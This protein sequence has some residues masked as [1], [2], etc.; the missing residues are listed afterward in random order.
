MNFPDQ[1]VLMSLQTQDS[2]VS[3]IIFLFT[4]LHRGLNSIKFCH[5]T[6]SLS[7][8][9]PNTWCLTNLSAEFIT[10]V[11]G[12]RGKV[13]RFPPSFRTHGRVGTLHRSGSAILLDGRVFMS[14]WIWQRVICKRRWDFTRLLMPKTFLRVVKL[15]MEKCHEA[16]LLK[17]MVPHLISF[18]QLPFH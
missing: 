1:Q 15:A 7:S 2:F 18:G 17:K 6:P 4:V 11:R 10:T 14:I 8:H 9:H 12:H 13:Y 3:Q 16:I 5:H